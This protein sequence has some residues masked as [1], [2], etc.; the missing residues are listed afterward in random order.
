MSSVRLV[1]GRCGGRS[2]GYDGGLVAI[3]ECAVAIV[4]SPRQRGSVGVVSGPDSLLH[5]ARCHATLQ[6]VPAARP[7]P[8]AGRDSGP[9]VNG[10]GEDVEA[11]DGGHDPL[12]DSG[13]VEVAPEVVHDEGDR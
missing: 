6:V 4:G 5:L 12:D 11:E 2:G 10:E 7:V 9:Q 8:A 13:Y 3:S 1:A